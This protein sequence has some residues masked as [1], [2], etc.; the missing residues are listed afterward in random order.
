M[1]RMTLLC[2]QVEF[3][4]FAATSDYEVPTD[5]NTNNTYEIN[6]VI[7]DGSNEVAQAV[8]IIITDVS[9]APEFVGFLQYFLIEEND[10]TVLTVE[11]ADPEGDDLVI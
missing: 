2:Q 11:V 10:N 6:V 7:S 1:M 9:E 3:L 5:A 4:S 8:S